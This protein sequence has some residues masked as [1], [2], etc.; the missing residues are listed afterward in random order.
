MK[1]VCTSGAEGTTG[2]ANTVK[3][4]YYII[5]KESD[6]MKKRLTMFLVMLFLIVGAAFSQT[7]VSGTVLYQEDLEPVI[8]ASVL[9]AG[10]QVGT[11]TDASGKFSLTVPAGK[12]ILRITYVGMEPIEVS[13]RPNMRILLTADQKS[14]DEVIV[15]AYG[16][17]KKAAFTGSASMVGAAELDKHVTTNVANALVGSVSGLQIRGSSGAPGSDDGRINIRGI[18]SLYASTD[19]LIIVDGAP[20]GAS[21]TNLSQDDI[22]SVS[23]LKDAD[24]AALYG[25]R[26]A[27]GVIIITTKKG[28]KSDPKIN[29]N[30][31]WGANSRAIQDYETI[32]DPGQFYEALYQN[33]NNYALDN[34]LAPD[35]ANTWANGLML[36]HAGYQVYTVP[37]GELLIGADGKLNP[38]A[39]LG[40]QKRGADGNTYYYQPDNWSD[41]AYHT[42]FRQ[43]YDINVSG[44]N[45]R[46]DFYLSAGYLDEDG[47]ID[48]SGYRRFN[49]RLKAN[50]DIKDWL[51]VGANVSYVS[52][53]TTSNPNLTDSQLGSTNL[54]YYVTMIAPIY[55]IWVR[56]IDPATGQPVIKTDAY[57]N[58]HYDY[59]RPGTDYPDARA[60]LQTGNPLG[61]NH[62]N[63]VYTNGM[64]LQGNGYFDIKFTDWL[65][66]THSSTVNWNHK[67]YSDYETSLYG[68]KVTVNG[69]IDKYQDD[70]VRQNHLQTLNFNRQFGDHSVAVTLGHEW[71]QAKRRYLYAAGQ[72]LFTSEVQEISAAANN[73]YNSTSTTSTYNV[74]GWFG[75]A[76]YNYKDTYYADFS[77]R[78]DASSRFHKDHRWGSFWS[79]GG[80]WLI[81]KEKFMEGTKGWLDELKIKASIGQK[82][83]DGLS[84]NWYFAERYSLTRTSATN[85]SPSFAGIGNE[86][87]TW[88]TTTSLNLGL[89]FS[90]FKHRLNGSFDFYNNKISDLLAWLSI[91]ESNGVRGYWGNMG[92]IRNTGIEFQLSGDIIRTKNITWNVWA[93]IAHNTTKILKLPYSK[94]KVNGGFAETGNNIQMWYAEGGKLYQPFLYSYAGVDPETGMALYWYDEDLSPLGGVVETNN[95]SKPG[96][97]Y[98]GKTDDLSKA[99]R[100]A[101]ESLLPTAT[102]GF[103]TTLYAYG[104]DASLNFDYQL[105][106]KVYDRHYQ[107]L[108]GNVTRASDAGSALH[109][110]AMQAWTRENTNTSVPRMQYGDDYTNASSDRWLV[111]ARYLN[112]QSFS[113]GYTLPKELVSKI[114]LSKCRVYV[115]GEN[116][117]FWSVR[118]GLDPRFDFEGNEML[119]TYS[120]V[121]TIM[122]GIQVTF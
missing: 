4:T 112:F 121:R 37:D 85:M 117:C 41:E 86:D 50:Y 93:N 36:R 103:G 67:T 62:Y 48:N 12:S 69:Q 70:Y 25:A 88:E 8:G 74:E 78:R 63:Q 76:L 44:G 7:K 24:S 10:T 81:S 95:T 58:P 43:E 84:S 31:R 15:V 34:G 107:A 53:K 73:Q 83:N 6:F 59:G 105:G 38:N 90:L 109:V 122:G 28:S 89:E 18:A 2:R 55:P 99:T 97:K 106:G 92:D 42:A 40:Y 1:K 47:I 51:R 49:T 79:L 11:M 77:Y 16:T 45:D 64:Q 29:V 33:Y 20:Y 111:S 60:F 104:F 100:Y 14:L 27:A 87:I 82:G 23:V 115:T 113:I 19:P 94:I 101:N 91:P 3:T 80:A 71:Y 102:G 46:G 26:G 120:P 68:P 65:K 57:G 13:A 32:N 21:L 110:D 72:G 96:S 17:Q 52:S 54:N 39:T 119:N 114:Y 22:E 5:N 98:S 61:S 118:K 35:R 9:V 30:M 66:F 116:L 56:I 75:R 108:M